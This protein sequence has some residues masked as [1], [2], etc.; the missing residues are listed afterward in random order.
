MA[1]DDNAAA[2]PTFVFSVGKAKGR[3]KPG[4][5]DSLIVLKGSTALRR[6]TNSLSDRDRDERARLVRVGV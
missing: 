1:T 6:N 3:A 4:D 2:K 5:G